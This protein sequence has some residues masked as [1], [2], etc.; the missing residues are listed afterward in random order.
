[1]DNPQFNG[2]I[3]SD[4]LSI[5]GQLLTDIHGHVYADKSVV[6]V[7]DFRLLNQMVVVM[8][9]KGGMKLDDSKQL[10]GVLDVTNGSVKNLLALLDPA[11]EHLDG[12]LN[13]SVEIGGTKDNPS[14]IVNGKINDVTIDDK[15]VGDATIDASLA[16][17]KFKI[18]TLKLPVGEGLI[19]MGVLWIS[20]DKLIYK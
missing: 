17:R 4:A 18:T 7:Q 10:F 19:A 3:L 12:Q 1:M 16:N 5:N 13:G 2:Y 9:A 8:F 15:V 14:V 11:D 6:N 20:M